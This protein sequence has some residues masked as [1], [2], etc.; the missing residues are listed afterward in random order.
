M[1]GFSAKTEKPQPSQKMADASSFLSA[2][3]SLPLKKTQITRNDTS[4]L[5]DDF[6][7]NSN[8]ICRLKP[9]SLQGDQDYVEATEESPKMTLSHPQSQK[10]NILII[11]NEE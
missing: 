4:P 8:C 9:T 1:A 10:S 5:I 3:S 2:Q 6:D 11:D 7:S